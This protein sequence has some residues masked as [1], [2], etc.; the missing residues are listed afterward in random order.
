MTLMIPFKN[1]GIVAPKR[2]VS[3][4]NFVRQCNRVCCVNKHFEYP[5]K[6]NAH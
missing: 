3:I 4:I 2:L 5:K 1:N 6:N